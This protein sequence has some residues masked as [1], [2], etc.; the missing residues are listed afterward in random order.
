MMTLSAILL[1]VTGISLT[2]LAVEIADY[3]GKGSS[4]AFELPLQLSGAL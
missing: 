3:L 1:A 4:K 2:F